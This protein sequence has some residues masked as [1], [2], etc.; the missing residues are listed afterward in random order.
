MP[1]ITD[2]EYES[3]TLRDWILFI[4]LVVLVVFLA[5]SLSGCITLPKCIQCSPN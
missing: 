2:E 1:M 5:M 3:M 4:S